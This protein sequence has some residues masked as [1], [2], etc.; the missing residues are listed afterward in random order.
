M[1]AYAGVV[2]QKLNWQEI[3][4]EDRLEHTSYLMSAPS[5]LHVASRFSSLCIQAKVYLYFYYCYL[6]VF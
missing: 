6:Y 2:L 4:K 1:F 5:D 3:I